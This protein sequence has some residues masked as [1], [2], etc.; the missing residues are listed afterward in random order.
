MESTTN[1][2]IGGSYKKVNLLIKV[3]NKTKKKL[4][5]KFT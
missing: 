5:L 2:P 3:Q 1:Y 4:K